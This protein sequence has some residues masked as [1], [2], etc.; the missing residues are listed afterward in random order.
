MDK[1]NKEKNMAKY[2]VE[3]K[4]ETSIVSVVI[5]TIVCLFILLLFIGS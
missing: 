4:E 3:V 5:G 1:T 2:V